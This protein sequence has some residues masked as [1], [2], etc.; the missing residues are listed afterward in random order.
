MASPCPAVYRPRRPKLSPLYHLVDNCYEK[1]KG[2]W[3]DRFESQYGRWRGFVDDVV[4]A[5][6]VPKLLRPFFL[7][8]RELLGPLCRAAWETVAELVAEAAG[9]GVRPGMVAAVHTA[10]SDLRWHPHVHALA[11]RGGWDPDGSWHPLPYLYDE[12]LLGP[13]RLELLDSWKSGHTGLATKGTDKPT[14]PYT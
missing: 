10:S 5:F 8:R 3:E 6:T 14:V 12:G 7:H 13:E 11:S 2:I 9:K 4:Y 1:V